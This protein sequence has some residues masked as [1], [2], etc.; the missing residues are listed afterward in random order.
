MW[1]VWSTSL[2]LLDSFGFVLSDG[3]RPRVVP[4]IAGDQA[5]VRGFFVTVTEP[6]SRPWQEA[7]PSSSY[8]NL[9]PCFNFYP[10]VH[11]SELQR[12][13]FLSEKFC[14]WP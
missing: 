7:E 3:P 6:N 2:S 1:R 8:R 9:G 13:L 14:H 12:F 10:F 11:G 4:S 5:T